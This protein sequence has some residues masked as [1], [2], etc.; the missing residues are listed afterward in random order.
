[1]NSKKTQQNSQQIDL[2][3]IKSLVT[4][5]KLILKFKNKTGNRK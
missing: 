3:I 4:K 5:Q 2:N 1:M